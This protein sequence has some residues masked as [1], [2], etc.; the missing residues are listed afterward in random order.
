MKGM[1]I[2]L[3]VC[4]IAIAG[5]VVIVRHTADSR[6]EMAR[7]TL[8]KAAERFVAC[9]ERDGSYNKCEP[10]SSRVAVTYRSRD[11]FALTHA[12]DF[13]ATY[14]VSREKDGALQRSCQPR[15]DHCPVGAWDG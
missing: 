2:V 14:T 12:A 9:Y 4:A 7:D 1:W 3:G 10:G 5:A 11:A 6:A 15:G 13:A 8:E